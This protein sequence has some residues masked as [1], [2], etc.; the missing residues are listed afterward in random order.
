[1][2][3]VVDGATRSRMMSGIKGRDTRPELLI[4]GHLH[5]AGFRYRVHARHLP[6]TPDI[7]LPKWMAVIDVRGCFWHRH[8]GCRYATTPATR[9]EFW[10]R[11]FERTVERDQANA[12][13]L[14]SL[15]WRTAVV[16]ECALRDS[17]AET[18]ARLES[19]LRTQ[20]GDIE[21]GDP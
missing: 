9:A 18:L 21:L 7:V 5:L 1:M 17:R 14:S 10:Q 8:P 6:G 4:R 15:G 11:K 12:E 3:D 2:A 20:R 16:W 19:W 13:A